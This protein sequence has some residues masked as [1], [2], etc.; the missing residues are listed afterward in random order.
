MNKIVMDHL[1]RKM[2]NNV[3]ERDY[4][5][6]GRR[7]SR[8]GGRRDM[9]RGR[10]DYDDREDRRD[11]EDYDDYDDYDYDD[12]D[13]HRE[14]LKLTKHD[15][16]KWKKMMEN[17]DGTKGEHYS[18]D[19]ISQIAQKLDI[20]F[21]E[22]SEKEFCLAVNM[23]YSDYG[24]VIKRY[25]Q[26]ERELVACA[27]MAKAFLEDPDGPDPSEKLALYYHCIVSDNTF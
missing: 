19:Q 3:D 14:K 25:V 27:E 10:S 13:E 17:Y 2:R 22:Y 24:H 8:R 15:I 1:M 11:Y 16:H 18:A 5:R 23:M 20:Q 6:G 4:R 7:G 9:R 26:P 12:Y 21:D